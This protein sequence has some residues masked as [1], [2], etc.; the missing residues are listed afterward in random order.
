VFRNPDAAP[1]IDGKGL[2]EGIVADRSFWKGYLKLSLVTCPVAVSPATTASEKL[3]FHTVNRATGN[4][5]ESRYVDAETGKSVADDDQARGYAQAEDKVVIL[6]DDELDDVALDTTRT[7]DIDRFVPR[8]TIPWIYLDKPHFLVPNDTVGEEAFVVIREAMA[9]S[10]V[11]GISRL[12]L[13]RRERAVM[14]EPRG[15]GIIVW[16]LRYGDEVR[17][18]D[19]YFEGIA[20]VKPAPKALAHAR[21]MIDERTR[22]WSPKLVQD[23]V[24]N[25]LLKLIASKKARRTKKSAAAEEKGGDNVVDLFAAL[26]KSL[27]TSGGSSKPGSP[28]GGA[29]ARGGA[30]TAR[31]MDTPKPRASSN[32]KGGAK[33]TSPAKGKKS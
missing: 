16:T 6:E 11:V 1:R 19:A 5:V 33:A 3:R 23:P 10:K 27:G 20:A 17:G 25:E 30:K 8:R 28:T 32:A 2:E 4:R 31:A 29:P 24:Q 18:K 26:R 22:K 7:I 13:Y 14:L 12:V 21:A 15:K 9:A